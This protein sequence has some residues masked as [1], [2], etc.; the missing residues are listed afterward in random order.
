MGMFAASLIALLV[1]AAGALLVWGATLLWQELHDPGEQEVQKRIRLFSAAAAESEETK[2]AEQLIRQELEHSHSAVDRAL[3]RLPR[4]HRF[5]RFLEQSGLPLTPS[6]FLAL[7][8]AA[9]LSGAVLA[10][11]VFRSFTWIGLAIGGALGVMALVSFVGARRDARRDRLTRQ[12][13]DAMDFIARSLRA[14]NPLAGALKTAAAELPDPLGGE[15]T[16]TFE[17][18]NYGLDVDEA[19]RDLA[20]RI[21]TEEIRFFVA[22]VLIQRSTGGNLAEILHN[23]ASLIRERLRV[24]GEIDIQASEMRTSARVLIA[25]PFVVALGLR[26]LNPDYLRVLLES[27]TGRTVVMVQVAL[28]VVGWLVMRQMTR[29]RV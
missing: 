23:L 9:G 25:L 19:L 12:L 26:I 13:P 3:L 17:E 20:A 24:R 6:G 5:D 29:F 7:A 4:M 27:P 14:G 1:F 21:D 16:D 8:T 2:P 28:M 15:L 10:A 11:V 18:L 22:A